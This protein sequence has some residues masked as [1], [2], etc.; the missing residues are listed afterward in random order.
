MKIIGFRDAAFTQ[1]SPLPA[2]PVLINPESYTRTVGVNYD[3]RYAQGNNGG[4][5]RYMGKDPESFSCDLVFDSTGIADG[6]PQR[7][8]VVLETEAFRSFLVGF[9]SDI[10]ELRH[11]LIIWGTMT[12]KGR[13]KSLSFEY[14]LFNANGTPIRAVA[15]VAFIGSYSNILQLAL[16]KLLS[17]DLTQTHEVVAGD[18]LPNLCEHYYG[19][20]DLLPRVARVNGLTTFRRLPTGLTLRF[21]PLQKETS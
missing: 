13:I 2:F 21:P 11:F 1:L 4:E 3:T 19:R 8:S 18:T 14:K 17:P 5:A 20:T 12:F 15:K 10:H 7:D 16:D 6:L 9:D